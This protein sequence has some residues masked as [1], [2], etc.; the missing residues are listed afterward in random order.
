[1]KT[2][3]FVVF[4]EYHSIEDDVDVEPEIFVT[5]P[6]TYDQ[7][8]DKKHSALQSMF[9]KNARVCRLTWLD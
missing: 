6:M 2:E 4:V 8:L 3:Y 1:M 7:C 5:Q 9:V